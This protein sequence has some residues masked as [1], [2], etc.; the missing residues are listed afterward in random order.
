MADNGTV[1]FVSELPN[2]DFGHSDTPGGVVKARYDFRTTDGRWANGCAEHYDSHRL[3]E[4]LG[5]GK[6][7][8]LVTEQE[9]KEL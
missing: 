3:H 6:G 9:R 7:Q 4:T 1:A 5:L 8:R 2:C